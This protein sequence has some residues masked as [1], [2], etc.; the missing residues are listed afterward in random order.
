MNL[1]KFSDELSR[2]HVV[3]ALVTYCVAA[4]VVIEVSS[5]V[6]PLLG[7]SAAIPRFIAITAIGLLPI[8]VLL[9]W[10]YDLTR[11][12][13]RRTPDLDPATAASL[14]RRRTAPRALGFI[15]LGALITVVGFAAFN[16]RARGGHS[17]HIESIAVLPFADLSPAHDQEYFTDGVTEELMN[18]L[19]RTGIRV[20]ARTSTFAYK[21]R[22]VDPQ[23][24]AEELRVQAILEGSI[25]RDGNRL[26][27]SATLIDA[28]D[29]A[30]LWRDSFERTDSSIFAIQ[31]E[32]SG[33]IV[34]A[35]RLKLAGGKSSSTNNLAAQ[36]LYF[37]GLKA[38]HDGNDPQLR[39]ALQYFDQA[40]ALD[41][42]YALAHAG[43]AKTYAVLPAFGDYPVA[44]ALSRG[45][46]AAARA[47]A[48]QSDLGEAYAARGQ[49]AQNLE[50]D[51]KSA[52][53]H[54]QRALRTSPN[55]ASTHQWYA[56]ALLMTGDLRTA[57]SEIDRA[58]TID[59]L[60][61]TAQNLRAYQALLRAD[62][63][64][65]L[66]IYQLLLREHPEFRFGFLNYAFAALAEREYGDAAQAL[67][68]AFPQFGPDVGVFVAAASGQGDR[69][70]AAQLIDRI[71]QTEHTSV[72]ALLQMA[73]GDRAAALK[74]LEIALQN[75]NDANLP[76]WLIHPLFR[77]M[78]N[79]A[80]FRK[81]LND[82]G[83]RVS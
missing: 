73:I 12:G 1:R 9:A 25:R 46:L 31:D 30:V 8:A 60:S 70:E 22:S 53:A 29:G 14:P 35:L 54:Y 44:D 36:E 83:V 37:K 51:L 76:Y 26:R 20:A 6:A 18:R 72:I 34:D 49:I 16:V 43:L 50:W 68:S 58:L 47:I 77:P 10:F 33:A 38:F 59:P 78:R 79:D 41:S 52:L 7:F 61:A 57:Q 64:N 4:W 40:I 66:R 56:E 39:A 81:I 19:A 69:T 2:R 45:N 82:V 48:L 28:T 80:R 55:D 15:A 71:A 74:T 5:T 21:G 65:A 24:I 62:G 32:I 42:T 75:A 13:V 11:S 23:I 17:T 27:I 63:A 67:V 3:R